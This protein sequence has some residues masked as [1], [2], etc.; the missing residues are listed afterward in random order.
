MPLPD[1][2][3]GPTVPVEAKPLFRPDV[4]RPYLMAFQLPAH[5]PGFR[6]TLAHWAELISSGR[7]DSFKEQEILPD[8]LTD[9][10]CTLL[11]YTRPADGGERYTISRERLVE[12]NGKFAD[13]VLGDFREGKA[14]RVKAFETT[15]VRY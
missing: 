13:A 6:P 9:F 15:A 2:Q 3:R 7:A 1:A 11:G 5:L 8:F 10:F 14:E 4:L 12:V